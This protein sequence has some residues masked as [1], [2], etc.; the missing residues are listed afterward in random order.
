MQQPRTY[1]HLATLF[2]V[3][4]VDRLTRV[5][6][7]WATQG[8]GFDARVQ[9]TLTASWQRLQRSG[10]LEERGILDH[11]K[12]LDQGENVFAEKMMASVTAAMSASELRHCALASCNA[13]EG[14]AKHFSSCAACKA[15]VYCCK[16]HQQAHWREHKPACR[17]ATAA[18]K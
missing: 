5:F 7:V 2:E 1:S 16:E 15:V 18:R 9:E 10:V 8:C 3:D 12:R 13:K 6:K 4:L 14:H 11:I 17:A